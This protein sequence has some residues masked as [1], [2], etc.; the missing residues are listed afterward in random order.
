[1]TTYIKSLI[2]ER[3]Q[4]FHKER[5]SRRWKRLRNKVRYAIIKVKKDYYRNRVQRHKK[6]NPAEWYKHIKVMANLNKADTTIQPPPHVNDSSDFKAVADSINDHFVSISSDLQPHSISDLPTYR[7]DPE[8]S[9]SVQEF[10]VYS[11]LRKTKAGKAGGPDGISSRIIREFAF[12][13]DHSY[14]ESVVPPQWK[15]AVVV[16]IPKEKPARW[17]KLRPVSLTDHFAKVAEGFM[18]KWLLEDIDSKIDPNQY[19]NRKGVSTTHYLLKLM[20]TL[21][22]NA[23][24]P[25]HLSNVVITNFSTAFDLVDHNILMK[26]FISMGVRPSVVTWI[27]SFLDGREQCVRYRS[28]TSDWKRLNGD[29][30]QGTKLGPLGFV[31]I[32]NDAAVDTPFV[33]LK[34]V[35]YLTL[36]EPISASQ[37]S[38]M[39]EHLDNFE[40]WAA[41]NYMKLNP[42][43][44]ASMKVSF[45]LN[46]PQ[47]PP[48]TI[49]NIPLQEVQV[50]KILGVNIN[51]DLRWSVHVAE[52]LKKANGRL[53]ML[54]LLKRFNLPHDDLVT[55]FTGF[56]RPLAEYAAP[57][58]HCG[59]TVNESIAL[60]RIQTR[61]CKIIMGR[62]YSSYDEALQEC[63]LDSL[64]DRRD[65]LSLNFLKSLMESD[66]FSGWVPPTR[67]T[68][69]RR[70]LR[71]SHRL[72]I[73]RVNT[74]RCRKSR[75][76]YMADLWNKVH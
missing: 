4:V 66:Q 63:G 14:M 54:K 17:D 27:A 71:N 23:Y 50:A 29:V 19:G 20:A 43:K 5:R 75:M 48:L 73:P 49:S 60:E 59:L 30:P 13:L 47:E 39:Q 24:K 7:P 61:A 16:P 18:A 51:D 1:M 32:A 41:T 69:H 8:P 57:V 26:K 65:Q 2:Q 9:P 3:Q 6:A 46:N 25:G 33:T 72:S 22:M 45:L 70:N 53:Y 36:V 10:E 74:T 38:V 76:L 31:V 58:W 28:H 37:P 35:D 67:S 64:S 40:E 52:I 15:R 68:V 34:Y 11:M 12:E 21:H 56:V 44:C 42:K 62:H 55:I